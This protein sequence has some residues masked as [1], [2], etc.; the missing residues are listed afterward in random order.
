MRFRLIQRL[1]FFLLIVSSSGYSF[2][3][4]RQDDKLN[5][6]DKEGKK[7]GKWIYFG[8]D[9]PSEGYPS[10]G[11]IEEGSYKDDRKEGLWIKYHKDGVTPKLK[12][13]Y[14]NN[15]PQGDYVKLYANGKVQERGTFVRNLYQDSLKRFHENGQIEY[16]ANYNEEGKEQGTVKY[17][18]ANGQLEFE[19][20]AFNGKPSGK[21]VRYYENGDVKEV[22]YY[23]A[24][25]GVE[26]SEQREMVSP[27]VKVVNPGASKE[28]AP[29]LSANP[30]T[31]GVKF[32][33]NG[34]NKVY[35]DNDEIWQDGT[36][37]NG[38]LWDG[39]VYEYDKDGILL[40]VKVY[41]SGVYHSDGQL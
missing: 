28:Q 12:G 37:K 7:Q 30:Q 39:K 20:V 32:Q 34:Y 3:D 21:A 40:K 2:A 11:K 9:R 36:F 1:F 14:V 38:Q 27:P 16:E 31:K 5:Q 35:N 41:K 17:F 19:Y 13:E 25:G 23:G 26:K 15:R 8:K 18:Y 29:K 10:N 4:D 24:D 6:K 33:P 22:I